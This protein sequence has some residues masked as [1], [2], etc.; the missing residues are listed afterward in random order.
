MMQ[1]RAIKKVLIVGGGTAGWMSAAMLA[2]FMGQQVQIQLIES[3]AIATV[4]VGEATI[5]AIQHFNAALG[6]NEA[7]FLQATQGT[8]KLGIQ[9]ENW[10]KPGDSYMHAFGP[11][12]KPLGFTS[13]HHFW[14]AAR[15][16]GDSRSFWE[17]SL[18]YQAARAGKYQPLAQIP[19]TPLQGLVH[20]YHFDAGLYAAFLR[21]YSERLGVSRTE[22]TIAAVTQHPSEAIAEVVLTDGQK[23]AADL[24]IDCSGSR[25]LLIGQQLAVGYEDWQ[26]WLPCDSALAVPS[27][28]TQPILPYT[29]AIARDAGWQWRIPLQHRT[30][31]GLVYNSQFLSDEQA[32]H[33]LM[34]HLDAPAL[35]EPRKISFVT[36]RRKQQWQHNCVAIGLSSGFLEPLE[37][38]SIHLI[39]S[40][41]VRLV[42]CFPTSVDMAKLRQEYNRQSAEEYCAIRDFIILHYHLNQRTDQGLWQYCQQMTLPDSLAQRIA[43]FAENA[44][45]FRQQ[46]ELFTEVAW[47]QVMLG[48]HVLPKHYHPLAESLS[49]G[50]L[51]GFLDDIQLIMQ[52]TA[53]QL[54]SHQQFLQ[55]SAAQQ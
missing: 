24:F 1:Q 35:A 37:S 49:A 47:Q 26:H 19:N 40:A 27:A 42:Q 51:T 15:A 11:I 17:F 31:N 13:F 48:Q 22:G 3:D 8:I 25:A 29:R 38:T 2:R 34:H 9:F 41:I 28:A 12:G 21:R 45:V 50:Q 23:L 44:A 53:A 32:Q 6:I 43:L 16:R 39:Q 36:G 30:G 20:A 5:P 55:Q 10:G 33:T 18:N 52:R 7:E 54:P 46:D 14:L 4:G